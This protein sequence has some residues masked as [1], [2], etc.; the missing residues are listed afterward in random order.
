[1]TTTRA[2]MFLLLAAAGCATQTQAMPAH[3]RATWD[4]CAPAVEHHCHLDAHGD[5][6]A[7]SR[8][9]RDAS[10]S[11]ASSGDE[12]MLRRAGCAAPPS[13]GSM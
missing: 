13:G 2:M 12:A 7:E 10:D 9:M 8:C 5:P 1:M 11:F 6:S 4:R 3:L